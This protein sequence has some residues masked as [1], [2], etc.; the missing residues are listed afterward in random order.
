VTPRVSWPLEP[1]VSLARH[2]FEAPTR[3]YKTAW[4]S[5]PGWG[6]YQDH[7]TML[8]GLETARSPEHLLR[9]HELA[10]ELDLSPIRSWPRTGGA[11]VS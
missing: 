5:W 11:A 10:A 6:G 8:G 3:F 7:F 2:V 4:C 9:C 1:T